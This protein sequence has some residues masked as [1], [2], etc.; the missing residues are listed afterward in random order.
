MVYFA[1]NPNLFEWMMKNGGVSPFLETPMF[2]IFPT[3][4][5]GLEMARTGC[6]EGYF[7]H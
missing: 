4:I 3:L 1:E 2:I 5:Q 6:Y 7:N